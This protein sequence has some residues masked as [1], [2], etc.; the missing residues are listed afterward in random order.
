MN[1]FLVIINII[2]LVV[3]IV[4]FYITFKSIDTKQTFSELF[5]LLGVIYVSYYTIISST[6]SI[7]E[8]CFRA[9]FR[10]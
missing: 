10:E 7:I 5:I 6:F 9:I 8:F 4:I 1:V 2:S 3:G